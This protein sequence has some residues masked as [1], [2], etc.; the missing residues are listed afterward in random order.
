MQS[1]VLSPT[2]SALCRRGDDCQLLQ[3]QLEVNSDETIVQH[4][5]GFKFL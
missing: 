2:Q 3:R 4:A 1:A 5:P